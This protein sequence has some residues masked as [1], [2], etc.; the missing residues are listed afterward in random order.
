MSRGE[1]FNKDGNEKRI[2]EGFGNLDGFIC[3]L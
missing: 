2:E 1:I 3:E